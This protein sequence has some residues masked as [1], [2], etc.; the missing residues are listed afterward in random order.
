ML[1]VRLILAIL[2][3]HNIDS[4]AIYFVLA[5]PQVGLKEDIWM[6][7]KIVFHVYDKTEADSDRYY[8]MKLNKSLYGL[9]KYSFNWY[10]KLK[11]APIDRGF[12]PSDIDEFYTLKMA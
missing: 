5:F 10:K 4:E 6:H 12:K 2:K 9:K 11:T 7:N 3:I 1:S 8:I